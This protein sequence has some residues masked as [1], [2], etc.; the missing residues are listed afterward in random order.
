MIF[1]IREPIWNGGKRAVGIAEYKL[2]P[3][4]SIEILYA[5]KDGQRLYSDT[6]LIT[7]GE[8]LQYPIQMIRGVKLRIIPIENLKTIKKQCV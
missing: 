6:Y 3:Y 5:T 8:A 4:N 7:K 2:R 1:K